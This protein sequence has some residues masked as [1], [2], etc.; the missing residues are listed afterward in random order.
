MP[1]RRAKYKFSS[2]I[3]F[4]HTYFY[5]FITVIDVLNSHCLSALTVRPLEDVLNLQIAVE[6]FFLNFMSGC[7]LYIYYQFYELVISLLELN[8]I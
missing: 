1:N 4:D 7:F 2:F 5:S 3:R 6:A 8:V